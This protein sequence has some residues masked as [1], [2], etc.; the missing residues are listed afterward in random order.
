MDWEP[1]TKGY[2]NLAGIK[3]GSRFGKS[4]LP[5]RYT[6]MK[7]N[8]AVVRDEDKA[9]LLVAKKEVE[10]EFEAEKWNRIARAV[11]AKGGVLYD[12]RNPA[13]ISSR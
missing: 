9:L 12:V 11:E 5:N 2:L 13:I 7:D 6:R 3:D 10:E 8:F 1:L 4:T